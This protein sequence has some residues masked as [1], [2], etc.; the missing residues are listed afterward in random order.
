MVLAVVHLENVVLIVLDDDRNFLLKLQISVYGISQ[1]ISAF[2]LGTNY[3]L[4]WSK[5]RLLSITNNFVTK[6]F[7]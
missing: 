3:A 5:L 4:V 6:F 7:L 1:N 2:F